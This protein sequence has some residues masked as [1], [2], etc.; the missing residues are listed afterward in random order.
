MSDSAPAQGGRTMLRDL[1]LID[2]K[3]FADAVLPFEPLTVLIGA[4][5]SGKS[6]ALD[7]LSF[8][9]RAAMGQELPVALDGDA[10]SP[11]LRGGQAGAPRSGCST[12]ELHV[13]VG[14]ADPAVDYRYEI[15]VSTQPRAQ[16]VSEALIELRHPKR[17]GEPRSK[18]LFW[19]DD[20]GPQDASIRARTYNKSRGAPRDLRRGAAILAQLA[21]AELPKVVRDG[22]DAVAGVLRGI[23]VLDPVPA[24]MRNYCR[25][26]DVLEPDGSTV[27][28][29]LQAAKHQHGQRLEKRLAKYLEALPEQ[30]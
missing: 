20:C 30:Q 15:K 25:I 13:T 29:V 24:R 2:W 14:T 28:G 6:N 11:G 8:L 22:I 17:G 26:T 23:F 16:L 7:A 5:G 3:S 21:N 10:A 4:N 18:N 19:T 27:T 1:R 9:H 12:F